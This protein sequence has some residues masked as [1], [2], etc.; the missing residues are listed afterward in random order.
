VTDKSPLLYSAKSSFAGLRYIKSAFLLSEGVRT[1]EQNA[2]PL[3]RTVEQ[4][5]IPL[6]RKVQ[7]KRYSTFKKSRA[8]TLQVAIT[9]STLEKSGIN[10]IL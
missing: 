10:L 8:K 6:L 9:Y 7:Q 3:L 5:A 4:N 2:I 1:V